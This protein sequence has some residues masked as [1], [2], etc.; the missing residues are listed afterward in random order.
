VQI[1]APPKIAKNLDNL[2][3]IFA[4]NPLDDVGDCGLEAG[5]DPIQISLLRDENRSAASDGNGK[6]IL[7]LF[8][9]LQRGRKRAK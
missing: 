5:D 7:R 6:H 4:T 8:P 1:N 3:G 2:F 9:A